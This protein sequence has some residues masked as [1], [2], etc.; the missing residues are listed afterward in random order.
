MSQRRMDTAGIGQSERV[1][2]SRFSKQ[3]EKAQILSGDGT[4]A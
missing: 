4:V 1:R 3:C 2:R